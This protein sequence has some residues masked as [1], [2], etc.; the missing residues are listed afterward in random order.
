[1]R[2]NITR[3]TASSVLL[4]TLMLSAC[5]GYG[6]YGDYGE[7]ISSPVIISNTEHHVGDNPGA[8]GLALSSKFTLPEGISYASLSIT[9]VYPNSYGQSGPAVDS[10]PE[11]TINNVKVGVWESD[12]RAHP[13]CIDADL[14][15][16]CNITL[17]YNITEMVLGGTNTFKI[18][19]TGW[20]DS[21]D[22]FVFSTVMVSFE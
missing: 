8:E 14:E 13:N 20:G 15:F 18:K 9:F 3:F 1:M 5:G 4:F 17:S 12:L 11:I 10:P 2:A 7:T 21:A 22:D 6:D 16:I 19:S